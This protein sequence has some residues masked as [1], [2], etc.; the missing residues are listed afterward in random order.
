MTA[1]DT[2]QPA[3]RTADVYQTLCN[4]DTTIR[5]VDGS[6]SRNRAR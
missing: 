3:L 1:N 5:A 4:G 2:N 6:D